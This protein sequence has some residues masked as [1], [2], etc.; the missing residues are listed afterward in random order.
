MTICCQYA[1][2]NLRENNAQMAMSS[3]RVTVL[4]S[5]AQNM[6]RAHVSL[7]ALVSLA[8]AKHSVV[9]QI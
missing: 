5:T 3:Q 8:F 9:M 6:A 7:N 1:T 2:V 4:S